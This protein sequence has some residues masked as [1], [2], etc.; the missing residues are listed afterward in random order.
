M[1]VGINSFETVIIFSGKLTEEEYEEKVKQYKK[2]INGLPAAR[3]RTEKL[4]S[5]LL[6]PPV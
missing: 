6:K 1:S 5:S 4:E 3:I 2:I